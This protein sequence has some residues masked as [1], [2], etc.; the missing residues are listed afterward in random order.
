MIKSIATEECFVEPIP[1]GE[2]P[3]EFV[4]TENH[5]IRSVMAEEH[6]IESVSTEVHTVESALIE[7]ILGTHLEEDHIEF[8][9]LSVVPAEVLV[10]ESFMISDEEISS[11]ESLTDFKATQ[12]VECLAEEQ[13]DVTL[14][15]FQ[16]ESTTPS[17]VIRHQSFEDGEPQH[18]TLSEENQ[19]VAGA[20]ES[21]S[22]YS[23]PI[24]TLPSLTAPLV[25]LVTA[26]SNCGNDIKLENK[27]EK[28]E[29]VSLSQYYPNVSQ[30]SCSDDFLSKLSAHEVA[31][32]DQPNL[33]SEL[34]AAEFQIT[35]DIEFAET[36]EK[37]KLTL[38][39][40]TQEE[41]LE[42][43]SQFPNQNLPRSSTPL[44]A[45][46]TDSKLHKVFKPPTTP[47]LTTSPVG[48]I[49][50]SATSLDIET[51]LLKPLDSSSYSDYVCVKPSLESVNEP[52]LTHTETSSEVFSLPTTRA[53]DAPSLIVNVSPGY[54]KSPLLGLND[55]TTISQS[56]SPSD[57]DIT[58]RDTGL[59]E[60][61]SKSKQCLDCMLDITELINK[62]SVKQDDEKHFSEERI[63]SIILL[64]G[65]VIATYFTIKSFLREKTLEFRENFLL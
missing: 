35:R 12:S 32:D 2:S 53:I 23:L 46:R 51:C 16:C 41:D 63:V 64:W 17:N 55:S 22:I 40:D 48:E 13:D 36:A 43:S 58:E 33:L 61:I 27:V 60:F 47:T 18:V 9:T 59:N 26:T 54:M 7:E 24:F 30:L 15:N 25:P 42:R 31:L 8:F 1:K 39:H 34:T 62:T 11:N 37:L 10:V 65:K 49:V 19:K 5:P 21:Y 3:V 20:N 38:G 4:G 45:N 50:G 29:P 44:L 57:S 52:I 6:P 14:V 28:V 56:T